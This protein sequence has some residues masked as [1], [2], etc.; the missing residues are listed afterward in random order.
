VHRTSLFPL[1]LIAIVEDAVRE[2]LPVRRFLHSRNTAL[3]ARDMALR[4]G[5]DEGAAYL[6]G[7]FHDM[8]KDFK[9][10]EL[11]ALADKGGIPVSPMECENPALLHGKAA[12]VLLRER[13]GIHNEDVLEAIALHTCGERG[14]GGL[15]KIIF[16]ADKIE[17]S[18]PGI[19]S[20]IRELAAGSKDA[21]LDDLF[22]IVLEDSVNYLRK[23][24]TG[25][26]A[27]T[28]LIL[29]NKGSSL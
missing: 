5:F 27:E 24:G 22:Y 3:L 25:I 4:Y 10:H 15:A 14:M 1:P 12:A 23:E 21:A 26:A 19:S 13:F 28:L 11:F 18:R 9:D 6:A 16:I 17:F 8:G 7:I 20:R 29:E 2:A